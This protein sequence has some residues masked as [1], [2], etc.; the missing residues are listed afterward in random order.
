MK[1]RMC[2]VFAAAL[3]L[4]LSSCA[5]ELLESAGSKE[6]PASGGQTGFI[7]MSL[8]DVEKAVGK[9][10]S[11]K[12]ARF[13]DVSEIKKATVNVY[14]GKDSCISEENIQVS[15][16]K[17][18]VKIE[19]IPV[20]FNRVIE[21]VGFKSNSVEGK[22]IYLS[23]N[24]VSGKNTISEIKDGAAS[25]KGKA[26]LAL[27]NAGVDLNSADFSISDSKFIANKSSSCFD[28]DS[29]ASAYKSDSSVSPA[30]F[31]TAQGSVNFTNLVDASGYTV[32]LDD[33]LSA[34][35]S[36]SSDS[37]KSAQITDVASGTWTVYADDGTETKSVGKVT[38]KGGEAT[39][40]T[41][42]IGNALKGKV[43]IFAKTAQSNI[44]V[45]SDSSETKLNGDYP[46][47]TFTADDC[48]SYMNDATGWK[49]LDITT[50]YNSSLGT[51]NFILSTNQV[52]HPD[53]D[54][55]SGKSAT[56]WFDGT[57]FYDSDP[58]TKPDDSGSGSGTGGDDDVP[59]IDD[60]SLSSVKVN[61]SAAS[62][63][64]TSVT[65]RKT[66]TDD[67]FAVTS[68][69]A[70][71][72]DSSASVTYSATSGTVSAGNSETFTITVTNGAKTENYT[73][74]V[75]YTKKTDQGGTESEYYWTNKN[76][77]GTNKT[78]S[79]W[80]DWTEAEKIAQC[81]AYDDPR[82]WRGNQEVPYDVYALYAAYDD[83]NLYLMVELTNI[84]D[85]AS[86]MGHNYAASD[87]AWWDNRD[88]PLGF[89]I[90]TGKGTTQTS[91]LVLSSGSTEPI[92]GSVNFTDSEG[93]DFIFYGSSKYGYASH[94][95]AFVGVGTPGLF[96]LNQSTGYFSYDS[97]Y[98]LSANTGTTT[99]TA[100]IDVKYIR[101]C[102][103]SSTI[104]YESTPNDN[105]TTSA[106]TGEDLLASSTYTS[107]KTGDLDMSYQ[108]T[109]PL[110]TLGISK[111][112]LE[113]TGIGVRQ[114]TTNSGSLMDCAPW[115]V[116]MVDVAS[117]E[118]SD[119]SDTSAE[120]KDVD[121]ITSAQ[122]RVGHK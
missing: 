96:K 5:S 8:C 15:A 81:A 82:T 6:Q 40:F 37:E 19:N 59:V 64:G 29:F 70:T 72:K 65:F 50:S 114:L 24:I 9:S 103:V 4:L 87:N 112:Y 17:G 73:L 110:S 78:I 35:L 52:K 43:L 88:I 71:P 108:Y 95:N 12:S 41:D 74:T 7:E 106:Q 11:E 62:I 116:S 1:K 10:G 113:N 60:V 77:Y 2:A 27:M 120:K 101:Q 111:D 93:F 53:K 3:G 13:L 22:R 38:V 28:A 14:Y 104:Y 63:S 47:N 20:G 48:S 115:D 21:V 34:K 89:L 107:V 44:Y 56:F 46:G 119:D 76:G 45:W 16:G 85:R 58:T 117:D 61:G 33:P 26:Y 69:E 99:G 97:D 94:K 55:K 51:I 30:D 80:S 98:C 25:A 102:Q 42:A 54:I 121:N 122:A 66:G 49:M 31:Y 39:D 86:F 118:C 90:N 105:R 18:T 79:D 23:E 67:S 32:Y 109:I 83:T 100:G 91:P 92:W 84:V 36:V 75:S 57:D 68:V